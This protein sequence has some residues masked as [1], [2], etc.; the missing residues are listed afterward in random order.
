MLSFLYNSSPS[1]NFPQHS[2]YYFLHPPSLSSRCSVSLSL[3]PSLPLCISFILP[4]LSPRLS[5]FPP[6][7]AYLCV[8]WR[9][10]LQHRGQGAWCSECHCHSH[11]DH[12]GGPSATRPAQV[13]L[14]R[15]TW[16]K[17]L[18]HGILQRNLEVS[19]RCYDEGWYGKNKKR[20]QNHFL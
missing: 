15:D 4:F 13:K 10:G 19:Q 8:I 18:Q 5:A 6:L 1:G 7:R 2:A 14:P 20:V 9:M 11:L 16:Q 12:E 17:S 3:S